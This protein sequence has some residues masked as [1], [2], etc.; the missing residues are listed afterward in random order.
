[1]KRNIWTA[2]ACEIC[3]RQG[4]TGTDAAVHTCQYNITDVRKSISFS[5]PVCVSLHRLTASFTT[6]LFYGS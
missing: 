4:G 1:M 6:T 5:T 2:S 3:G